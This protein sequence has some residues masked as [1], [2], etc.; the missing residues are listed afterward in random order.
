[1]IRPVSLLLALGAAAGASPSV[2]LLDGRVFDDVKLVGADAK[3]LHLLLPGGPWEVPARNVAALELQ[4]P[5]SQAARAPGNLYLRNGDCVRG[6]VTGEGA[7]LALEGPGIAGF[8]APLAEVVGVRYGR[9]LGAAQAAYDAMFQSLLEKGR[10]SVL[11][12]RDANPFPVDARVLE[13]TESA[14]RVRIGDREHDLPDPHRVYG[15]VLRPDTDPPPPPPGPRVRV[16]LTGGGR[17]TLPLE[18]ITGQAIEGGGAR[19]SLE[20]AERLEFLGGHVTALGDL[21]PIATREV[22]AFGAAP[23]WRRD[24]MVHGGPLVLADR[25]H[26]RGIGVHAYSRLEFAVGRRWRSFFVRCGIDDGAGPEGEALF[27]VLGD[28]RVLAEARCRRGEK[29]ALLRLDVAGVERLALEVD[30]AGSY[31]SD[32]GD[33]ADARLYNAE[34]MAPPPGG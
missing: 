22:A 9:L 17:L 5:T 28:G 11:V 15:F 7:V 31:A 32:F 19:V 25:R 20:R 18:R 29:P 13:V 16:F 12:Q 2:A 4:A 21:E 6:T 1:V 27:R 23:S 33:W 26:E 8:R 30:P 14:M 24:A 10:D 3:A 34:P